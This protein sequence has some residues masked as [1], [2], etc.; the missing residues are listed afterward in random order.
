MVRLHYTVQHRKSTSNTNTLSTTTWRHGR[1]EENA[2]FHTDNY[3]AGQNKNNANVHYLLS[4]NYH[5]CSVNT[6]KLLLIDTLVVK[7]MPQKVLC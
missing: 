4:V 1:G 5:S 6:R 7:E 3:G 2:H